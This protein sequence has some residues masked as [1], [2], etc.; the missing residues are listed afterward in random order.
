[1]V[2]VY[3]EVKNRLLLAAYCAEKEA[4][5]SGFINERLSD[6]FQ[7]MPAEERAR[8]IQIGK[9]MSKNSY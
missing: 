1:M 6:F 7:K 9:G 4:S 2:K 8:L 5:A 3:P